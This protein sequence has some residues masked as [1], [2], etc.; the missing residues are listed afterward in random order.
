MFNLFE[1]TLRLAMHRHSCVASQFSSTRW[2]ISTR[3]T[4][5]VQKSLHPLRSLSLAV[6]HTRVLFNHVETTGCMDQYCGGQT[7]KFSRHPHS[8]SG[9]TKTLWD[10]NTTRRYSKCGSRYVLSTVL[11]SGRK[12]L[13]DPVSGLKHKNTLF[14]V[15][16][17]NSDAAAGINAL[18]CGWMPK[19]AINLKWESDQTEG[20]NYLPII[21]FS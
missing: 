16:D 11:S 10:R 15:T 19:S 6:S 9:M 1:T 13:S 14:L 12:Y 4:R 18:L 8:S 2:T 17:A 7:N 21:G 5:T 20:I 3:R